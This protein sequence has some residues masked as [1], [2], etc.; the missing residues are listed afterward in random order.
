MDI[1]KLPVRRAWMGMTME[2][3]KLAILL[4]ATV[5]SFMTPFMGSSITI[6]LPAIAKEFS[7]DAFLIGWIPTSYRLAAAVFLVPFGRLA[8]MY[9]RK[10]I[11]NYGIMV[12]TASSFLA[13]VSNSAVFLL[14]A[15]IFQGLG[16]SMLF[17]TGVAMLTSVYPAGE[18]GKALGINVASTYSGLSLGPFLGGIL[19]QNLDGGVFSLSVYL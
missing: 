10:R 12:F 16:A 15:F 8:D 2:D 14:I 3:N 6:A 9:G 11:F 18:R 19:T 5:G 7:L 1:D 13:G 17:G 4:V